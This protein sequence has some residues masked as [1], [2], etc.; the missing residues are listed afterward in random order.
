MVVDETVHSATFASISSNVLEIS[1]EYFIGGLSSFRQRKAIQR[2]LKAESF[3]GCIQNLM[4]DKH[5][6]GFPHMKV[7][8]TVEVGCI[9]SYP[10]LEKDPCISSGVCQQYEQNEF[11]C[12]CEQ[13]YCIKA[14]Y[15]EH[16]KIFTR[17]ES[18]PEM[19]LLSVN[20]MQLLEGDSI[21]LSTAAI[22][23]LIDYKKLG[24][25]KLAVLI[26]KEKK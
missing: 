6:V 23:V 16:Y 5:A 24:I 20:P 15:N 17:S 13:A 25:L 7:T 18:P 4:V 14:D 8:H 19:E 26:R 3:N 1:E 10:C 12:Y 9:W 21:F 2:G 11:V 22:D